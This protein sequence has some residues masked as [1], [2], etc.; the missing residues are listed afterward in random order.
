MLHGSKRLNHANGRIVPADD[1]DVRRLGAWNVLE[2]EIRTVF[3]WPGDI[4]S[5]FVLEMYLYSRLDVAK[6]VG[7]VFIDKSGA[8]EESL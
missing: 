1:F 7:N 5:G 2:V 3:Q 6:L 8:A 4:Y